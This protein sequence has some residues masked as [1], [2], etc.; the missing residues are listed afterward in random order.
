MNAAPQENQHC[1]LLL[2]DDDPDIHGLVAGM[3]AS[4]DIEL[5]WL[6][7]GNHAVEVARREKPDLIL[8]DY[9]M[10]G[11]NGLE[12]IDR[13][14]SDDALASTP[15]VFITGNDS[16]KILT[17]CFKAG[18]ADYIR[19]PFCAPELRA[20]VRSLLDRKQMLGQLERLAL[21]DTLT[22]LPNRV[23]IRDRIQRAIDRA[24]YSNY[25]LLFL[26]FDR[27]KLVNDSLGHDAGDQLLQQ[28]ANRL[29][30]ATESEAGAPH[31]SV[32]MT[33]AR[34]GGDEFVVLLE[35]LPT[36]REAL[37][38]A[39]RLLTALAESYSLAGHQVCSTASIGV[40][41][42]DQSHATPDEVLRDADTAMYEAKSAGRGRY[43]LFDQAMH[44]HAEK[45]LRIENDL[46]GAVANA[47][48]FL[49]YQPIVSLATGRNAGFEAL[50]RWEHP[51]RGLISPADFLPAA[52]E[53]GLIVP[54][55]MWA[56][57]QACRD[58]ASWQRLLGDSAP[59]NIHVNL[60]R[61]Q[62]LLPELVEVVSDALKQHAVAPE[63]LHLEVTESE[64]MHNPKV[65]QAMLGELRQLGVK[66]DMDDF[67]TG[68]S[69]L[70][71]LQELPIDVLKIDRSFIV[72]MERSRSFAALVHA[73]TN[74]GQN[75]G[76]STV[77]E[78]IETADQLAM[79]QTMDCDFGQGYLFAKPMP[80]DEV[81]AYLLATSQPA[82][83]SISTAPSTV[84]PL[85]ANPLAE[86][87]DTAASV[88]RIGY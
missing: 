83:Q 84:L 44:A 2:I 38:M 53:T 68:H 13:F 87:A 37:R 33:A 19:K 27:F 69:S 8:L 50:L 52:E 20:R 63:R 56:L 79:L 66:I 18:A 39:D 64:I 46:R 12:V 48:F 1:R 6:S 71:C 21:H 41:T 24:Q 60:S 49:V 42:S 74:L 30:A 47:E 59:S 34:L 67:G 25:A 57:N 29:R 76:L 80:A 10:P 22:G 16:H 15:V 55:G 45:R 3:L 17:A 36:P 9:E 73:I 86:L 23:S 11:A 35:D 43:V 61:K 77:A 78:G 28:I 65:A 88:Y 5:A 72:N 26:D 31:G 14:R 51:Q 4:Q 82:S 40:V 32:R 62:L 85:A 58:F 75:L 54:I 7:D 70:A 81:G